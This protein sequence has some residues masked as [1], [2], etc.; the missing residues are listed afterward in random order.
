MADVLVVDD[1][2]SLGY[3]IQIALKRAGHTCRLC[4]TAAAARRAC[5][6]K[7]P[8]VALVDIHLPDANGLELLREFQNRGWDVPVIVITAYGTVDKAVAAMKQGAADFIQK[9]LSMEEVALA[10]ERCLENRQLRSQLDAY[11]HAQ[12][13]ESENIRIIGESPVMREVIR[14]ADKIAAVPLEPGGALATT[15]LLGETGTGK[16]VVA[17]YIHHRSPWP[18][19]P[20]VQVNCTAIPESLFEAELFGH[21]RG[22]FTD[23]KR[24]KRGL[25]ET[26]EEG[27][28]FLDEIG[29]MPL[30]AQAKLL[31]AIESGRFRRLGGTNE[32]IA[33]VRV[34]AATNSDL[35][36]KVQRGEF[37]ADLYYRL[38]VFCIEL[39]PLRD[40]GDDLFL[41]VDH[42]VERFAQKFHKPPPQIPPETRA[43][44]RRYRWPGNVREL[45][46]VLQRAVLLNETGR[47]EPAELG[48]DGTAGAAPAKSADGLVFDFSRGDCTLASVEKRLLQAALEATGYNTSEAARLVGLTRG[49]FRHRLEKY[50]LHRESRGSS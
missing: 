10:V 31:V 40:R 16:E 20:F 43:A 36:E 33:N 18:D 37:R 6:E 4:D 32:R 27:T 14:L 42:F 24:E 38:K 3:S 15:L 39:P 17:R 13:R 26:A 45:A 9:P 46:N 49:A 30:A 11:R 35:E 25:L 2:E 8:D 29:D 50:G 1:Q 12:K 21:E 5:A 41:L 44:I 34:M 48:L 19:R 22:T 7:V 47:I 28:L 23:A